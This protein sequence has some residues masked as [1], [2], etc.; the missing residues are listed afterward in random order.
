MCN[1]KMQLVIKLESRDHKILNL[2]F[3]KSQLT[4]TLLNSGKDT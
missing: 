1:I 4:R 3:S 2:E